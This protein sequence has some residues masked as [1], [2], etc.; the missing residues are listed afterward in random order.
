[1]PP[2][3]DACS[4]PPSLPAGGFSVPSTSQPGGGHSTQTHLRAGRSQGASVCSGRSQGSQ[5]RS[6]ETCGVMG[7]GTPRHPGP[8][9]QPMARGSSTASESRN[10]PDDGCGFT[11]GS[12]CHGW[13]GSGASVL[14]PEEP[15]GTG[16]TF[17][18]T[19]GK[20]RCG[21]KMRGMVLVL[22]SV[23]FVLVSSQDHRAK[24]SLPVLCPRM[25]PRAASR[26]TSREQDPGG[27][28]QAGGWAAKATGRARGAQRQARGQACGAGA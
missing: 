24:V 28:G 10:Q 22:F 12:Q 2:A 5:L 1:M 19:E 8:V 23:V 9:S 17:K 4:S 6:L 14:P 13:R 11:L 21:F 18:F 15:Q 20:V 16:L 25:E 3:Q 26:R 27:H 7:V